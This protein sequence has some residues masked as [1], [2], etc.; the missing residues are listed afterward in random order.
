MR[1]I[2]WL[3]LI[4]AP[5]LL[6][7]LT[8][9]AGAQTIDDL[10]LYTESYAPLNFEKD[11]QLTG[12]TIDVM[13]EMLKR[14]GSK[15]TRKDIKLL[16]W[17]R[18]YVYVQNRPNTALFAMTRTKNREQLFHWVGPITKA[19]IVLIGKEKL[20]RKI[21][22]LDQLTDSRIVAVNNDVGHQLLLAQGMEP[23][24]IQVISQ[25]DNAVSLL[26]ID[27]V[28]YWAYE[29]IVAN[30]YLDTIG[31]GS[32][33]YST[34]YVLSESDYYFAFNRNTDRRIIIEL[35]K[36]LESMRKDGKLDQILGK[37]LTK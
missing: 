16:P 3:H 35:R 30:W 36:A 5:M 1:R 4:F 31:D 6:A 2:K 18:G 37:Y 11:G 10:N 14:A 17:A 22:S 12:I 19:R 20:T 26:A 25:P 8:G 27:R 7:W 9:T 34:H 23:D 33:G 29:Q 21:S 24:N 28:Q 32:A 13:E 15:Q